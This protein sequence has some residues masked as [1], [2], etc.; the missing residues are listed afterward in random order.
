MYIKPEI[1][2]LKLVLEGALCNSVVSP[3]SND[4]ELCEI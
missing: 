3:D 4:V 1:E 2:A